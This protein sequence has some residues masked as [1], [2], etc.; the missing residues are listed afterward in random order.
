MNHTLVIPTYNRPALLRRLVRYYVERAR[1]IKLLVLDSSKPDMAVENAK[2]LSN[3]GES[4][5]HVP[6]PESIGPASKLSSGLALVQ[7]PYASLCA[8]DDLVFPHGLLEAIAFLENHPDYVAAHGLCLNFRQ[9]GRNVH[10]AR[11]PAGLSNE[12]T[13]PGARI[14]HLLQKYESLYY[15]VF[16]AA[17]LRTIFGALKPLPTLVFQ[18]LFQSVAAA[19]KGK[20]RR[21]PD[22]HAVRQSGPP[23]HPERDKWQTQY[24]FA[25]DPVEV[26]EHYGAY[27]DEVWKF[28]EAH[29]QAPRMEKAAFYRTLDLAHA[30]YLSAGCPPEY[31]YSLLQ[32]NWPG[33]PYSKVGRLEMVRDADVPT[34]LNAKNSGGAANTDLLDWLR[35]PAVV[36]SWPVARALAALWYFAYSI[37]GHLRLNYEVRRACRVPW[38]CHLSKRIL[39]LAAVPEFRES[40]LELCSYLDQS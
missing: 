26:I 12:A 29:G 34:L 11:E 5:R 30:V 23:A 40:F 35:T 32:A 36:A 22:F 33:D 27:R 18:E 24:W 7:T 9:D 14:F 20:I 19:I 31:F 38:K 6:F 8:D 2:A 13:H 25:R 1:C 17:D 16:R 3:F 28:Y 37:P 4:V 21:F 39:W 10:I 15:A